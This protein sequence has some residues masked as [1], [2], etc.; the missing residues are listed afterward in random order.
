MT[1][2][3]KKQVKIRY[4][5]SDYW[6]RPCFE[7]KAGHIFSSLDLLYSNYEWNNLDKAGKDEVINRLTYHG[8]DVADDPLGAK[9]PEKYELVLV[10][11]FDS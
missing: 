8:K 6:C 4:I 7:D 5:G 1:T 11:S 9:I 3:E 2:T 10:D